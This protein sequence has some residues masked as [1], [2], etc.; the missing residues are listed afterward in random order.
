MRGVRTSGWERNCLCVCVCVCEEVLPA[1]G[2]MKTES[3]TYQ[4]D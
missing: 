4:N 3:G 2:E 1:V